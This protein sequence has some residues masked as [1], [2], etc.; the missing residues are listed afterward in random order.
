VSMEGG[1]TS[2]IGSKLE[3]RMK[4]GAEKKHGEG[5]FLSE[6]GIKSLRGGRSAIFYLKGGIFC[7]KCEEGKCEG[8][9]EGIVVGGEGK[10]GLRIFAV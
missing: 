7:E 2:A 8:K 9:R 4:V 10:F 6:A 1:E 3:G 5:L